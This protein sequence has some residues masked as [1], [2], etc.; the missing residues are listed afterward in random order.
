MGRS[1]GRF[2]SLGGEPGLQVRLPSAIALEC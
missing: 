2:D 1:V